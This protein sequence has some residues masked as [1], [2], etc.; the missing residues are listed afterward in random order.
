M[1]RAVNLSTRFVGH[2]SKGFKRQDY[3]SGAAAVEFAIVANLFFV[4]LLACMEFARLNMV[5]N[6]SQDAAYFAARTAIVP[7]ATSNEAVNE[8]D[9]IM[10]SLLSH[11]YNVHVSD[12]DS[13]SDFISVTVSVE[14][15]QV[16][17]FTPLFL[18]NATIQATARLRTERYDGFYEQ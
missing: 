1:Q 6:L 5:R 8:A 14:L 13:D 4:V 2:S 3:R 15:A 18:P 11:G 9:R 10:G 17:F 7:G 16:A 12:L